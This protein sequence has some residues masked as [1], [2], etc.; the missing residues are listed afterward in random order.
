MA[1]C[2]EL[3][4]CIPLLLSVLCG[5]GVFQAESQIRRLNGIRVHYVKMGEGPY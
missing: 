4:L 3:F 2:E 5:C 1:C